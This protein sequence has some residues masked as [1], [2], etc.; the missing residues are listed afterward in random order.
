MKAAS[1][2]GWLLALLVGLMALVLAAW[3]SNP[4][5]E[6]ADHVAAPVARSV[7]ILPSRCHDGWEDKSDGALDTKV[8]ICAKG[9]WRVIL[10][11]DGKT[12]DHA[13]ELDKP[14]A[15]IIYDMSQVPGW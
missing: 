12:P 8:F 9:N 2:Y 3:V 15:E 14:G 1:N 5:E 4:V 10:K 7:G 11:P 6:G 13:V